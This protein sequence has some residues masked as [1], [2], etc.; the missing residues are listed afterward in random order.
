[1]VPSESPQV[2]RVE[3]SVSIVVCRMEEAAERVCREQL[4]IQ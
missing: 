1:M 3:A 2:R 4:G